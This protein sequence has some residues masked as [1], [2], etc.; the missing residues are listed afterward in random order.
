VQPLGLE[1]ILES[2]DH[3]DMA[4]VNKKGLHRRASSDS[5]AFSK[6]LYN[7]NIMAGC[8]A[9]EEESSLPKGVHHLV[10]IH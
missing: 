2:L 10:F 7:S 4:I 8:F 1:E 5:V 3:G 6:S 9:T